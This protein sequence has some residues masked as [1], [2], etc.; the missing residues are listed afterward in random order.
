MHSDDNLD[1]T[2]FKPNTIIDYNKIKVDVDIV[3]KCVPHTTVHVQHFVGPRLI[4]T[5]I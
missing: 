5:I 4:F 3:D 2:T 1:L